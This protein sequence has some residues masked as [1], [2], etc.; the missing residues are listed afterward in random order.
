[1]HR[2][3]G[4]SVFCVAYLFSRCSEA[5]PGYKAHYLGPTYRQTAAIA[6]QYALQ[7]A[8][9]L[10][11]QIN[12][13]ELKITFPNGATLELLGGE[14]ADSLRGRYSNLI[15]VDEAQLL[16]QSLWAYVLRPLLA[17][18]KGEAI[19]SGTPA[20]RHNLL[21]WAYHNNGDNWESFLFKH[22]ETDALPAEELMAMQQEMSLEAWAQEM[23]C[24]FNAAVQGAYYAASLRKLVADGRLTKVA[25]Q[26]GHPVIVSLDLGHNDL[27]P[28]LFS[29]QIG[30]A[31]HVFDTACYRFTSIP[32]M[33]EDWRINYKDIDRVILPHD[34]LVRDL[35]SGQ[36]REQTFTSMGL[37]TTIAPKLSLLEGIEMSRRQLSNTWIDSERAG[38]LYEGLA[39]YRSDMDETTG[40]TKIQPVHDWS[41]HWADAYR[42]LA[43]GD[44]M[45]YTG[46]G[47][48]DI[49][50]LAI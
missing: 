13:A 19:I 32:E 15:V 50:G 30:T 11:C 18:R 41:S 35:T 39:M 28:V 43:I 40:V 16:P 7:M 31:L 3:A 29:Q 42:Y 49:S 21:G 10:R 6:W 45:V 23:E 24:D 22:D 38:T 1:M 4:K 34:A 33:I 44:R 20:G 9:V 12:K 8:N 5:G 25:Y 17:D 26:E 47:N 14:N 48:R 36:T 2:R 27:M 37:D 46:W